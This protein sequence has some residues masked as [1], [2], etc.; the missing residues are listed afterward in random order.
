MT[1]LS[2]EGVIV[3][4]EPEPEPEEHFDFAQKERTAEDANINIWM[5]RF[6]LWPVSYFQNTH[7]LWTYAYVSVDTEKC[8]DRI[9][10]VIWCSFDVLTSDWMM[11]VTMFLEVI[12]H[13]RLYQRM[14]YG[15]G[16]SQTFVGGKDLRRPPQGKGQVKVKVVLVAAHLQHGSTTAIVRDYGNFGF[17]LSSSGARGFPRPSPTQSPETCSGRCG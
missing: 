10:H 7:D 6:Y 4:P 5:R 2:E 1:I 3:I 15:Y 14:G 16:G 11:L 8:F 13:M 17:G 9:S 12:G